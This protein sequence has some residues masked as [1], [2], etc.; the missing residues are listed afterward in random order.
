[1][2]RV[3]PH[4][5][6][7]TRKRCTSLRWLDFAPRS[8][9]CEIVS[10]RIFGALAITARLMVSVFCGPERYWFP[11]NIAAPSGFGSDISNHVVQVHD[12]E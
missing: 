5:F 8:Q 12:D 11:T 4:G 6:I 3:K 9:I 10:T 1:M 7:R 2:G